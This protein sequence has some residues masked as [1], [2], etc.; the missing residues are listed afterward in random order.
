MTHKVADMLPV[1]KIGGI[2]YF[3]DERLGEYRNVVAP[4]KTIPIDS[5]PNSKLQRPTRADSVKVFGG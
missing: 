5:V 3:R 4:W 2:L 1:Y